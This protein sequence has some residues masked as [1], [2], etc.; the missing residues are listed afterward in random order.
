[1]LLTGYGEVVSGKAWLAGMWMQWGQESGRGANPA[2]KS[3]PWIALRTSFDSDHVTIP[4]STCLQSVNTLQFYI[5]HADL[6]P[7]PRAMPAGGLLGLYLLVLKAG[8]HCVA[9]AGPCLWRA[10]TLGMSPNA[11][12]SLLSNPLLSQEGSPDC[13]CVLLWRGSSSECLPFSD[14][15]LE[16]LFMF[17]SCHFLHVACIQRQRRVERATQRAGEQ[18]WFLIDSIVLFLYSTWKLRARGREVQT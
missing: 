1:M 3:L 8:S 9:L 16:A 14:S 17:L 10:G 7:F 4:S 5:Q 13:Q 11:S 18:L 6:P 12:C 15:P 2:S